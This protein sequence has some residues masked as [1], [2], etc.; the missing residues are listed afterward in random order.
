[1]KLSIPITKNGVSTA[2][3]I[4]IATLDTQEVISG[5]K[6]YETTPE[7]VHPPVNNRDVVN[8]LYVD[9]LAG[10]TTDT[11]VVYQGA[12]GVNWDQTN[13]TYVRT[14]AAGYKSIQSLMKRCVLND[15]GSVNYY[16]HPTDSTKKADGTEAILDGTDGNVMVE[17]PKFYYKYNYNTAVGVVHEHSISLTPDSGYE[18]HD[19][20]VKG[21][22]EVGAR[23][24]PAY[25]GYSSGGK[26]ISRSGVYPTR[27]QTRAQFR[28]LAAA[29]GDGWHQL[30]FLLYEAITL[31][32][33]VEYGTMNT[34]SALG[35]GRTALS[36]GSW[37]GGSYIGVNGLS[38]HLG[39]AS[40]N[41]TYSGDADN[42]DADNSFM[43]YRGCENFF[44]N[45]WRM[46]DGINCTG[47]GAKE[48]YINQNP[49]TYADDVFTGDYVSTGVTT[50]SG[51][52]YAR[53]LGNSNQ[54]FIPTSV[55]G[56][57]SAVGTTDYF[58]TSSTENTIALVGSHA[59]NGLHSGPLYLHVNNAASVSPADVG[60]G[61]SR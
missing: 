1:M 3:T 36:G 28:A 29:N 33:I 16:L 42:V 2:T 11:T 31:L 45:I 25:L 22:A 27:A 30:D 21:G 54:G 53:E 52:G 4:D 18:L 40:G 7:V 17:I 57:G 61:V 49:L 38:N 13:D 47:V 6:V 12:Y 60:S 23:Y 10:L 37:V 43:S 19:C 5:K 34:Q 8:K 35:Q 15:D 59:D 48:I 26:L 55:S 39:N 51:S 58:Y 9:T 24:Y 20:F 41:Y 56:G 14:G 32:M 46:V 44:G 50:A